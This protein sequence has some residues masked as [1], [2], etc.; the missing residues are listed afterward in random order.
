[1]GPLQA[2]IEIRNVKESLS[3]KTHPCFISPVHIHTYRH[4]H[5]PKHTHT[6]RHTTVAIHLHI[7]IH[8]YTLMCTS[9]DTYTCSYIPTHPQVHGSLGGSP[10]PSAP[11]VSSTHLTKP[12]GHL[13]DCSP[14]DPLR[15]GLIPAAAWRASQRLLGGLKRQK[16]VEESE[17]WS[18]GGVSGER[19]LS[20]VTGTS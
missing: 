1:M 13:P 3:R 12:L 4:T 9:I 7:Q 19:P 18:T 11:T 16:W 8:P 15:P 17:K 20:G 10:L 14:V 2:K 5:T 6:H